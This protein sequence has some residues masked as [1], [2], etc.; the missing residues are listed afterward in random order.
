MVVY[1]DYDDDD[2]GELIDETD[3]IVNSGNQFH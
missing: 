1:V 3:L 2:I